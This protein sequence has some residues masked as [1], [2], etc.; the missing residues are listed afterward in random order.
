MSTQRTIFFAAN[1]I[2]RLHTLRRDEAALEARLTD[3]AAYLP[4]VGMNPIVVIGADR[5]TPLVL[6]GFKERFG[7]DKSADLPANRVL[8]GE[9]SA[10]RKAFV[11][12]DTTSSV[13]ERRAHFSKLTYLAHAP[14][15]VQVG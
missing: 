10:T 6:S 2:D 8:L 7:V 14:V 13:S 5:T 11:A 12:I 15:C 1:P 9:H 3:D 4:F